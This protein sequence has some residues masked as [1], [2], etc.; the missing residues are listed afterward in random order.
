MRFN[1]LDRLKKLL[2]YRYGNV[3]DYYWGEGG[4]PKA[5]LRYEDGV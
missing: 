4:L 3:K 2:T 5:F 1:D